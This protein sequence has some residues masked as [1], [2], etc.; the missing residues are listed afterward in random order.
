MEDILVAT[1]GNWLKLTV[2]AMQDYFF[3]VRVL[4]RWNSLPHCTVDVKTVNA[5]KNQ[6]EKIRSKQMDLFMDN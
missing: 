4:I 5:F 2:H 6:L 1:D 3:S